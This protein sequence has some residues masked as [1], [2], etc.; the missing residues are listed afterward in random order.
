VK[1]HRQKDDYFKYTVPIDNID[2]R[3][4]TKTIPENYESMSGVCFTNDQKVFQITW[5][6][7]E[8]KNEE[9]YQKFIDLL[10]TFHFN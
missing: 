7:G 8:H 6:D 3:S 2:G 1:G 9:A 5:Y 4:I 10:S